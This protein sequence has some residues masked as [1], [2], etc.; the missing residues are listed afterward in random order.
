MII[1]IR[2]GVLSA[3]A[4]ALIIMATA[5]CESESPLERA[6]KKVDKGI[7]KAGDKIERAGDKVKDARK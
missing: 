1:K 6:G 3:V 2:R 4:G 5:G 7:E